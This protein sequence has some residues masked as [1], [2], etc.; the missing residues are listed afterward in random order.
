MSERISGGLLGDIV[1]RAALIEAR[2]HVATGATPA[3]AADRVCRGAWSPYRLAVERRLR[4]GDGV[5]DAA[6]DDGLPAIPAASVSLL[7]VA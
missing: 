7:A 3:E 4:G 1:V 5:G 6:G 2:R